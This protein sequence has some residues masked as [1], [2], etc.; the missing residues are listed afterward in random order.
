M[1]WAREAYL[2]TAALHEL[3]STTGTYYFGNTGTKSLLYDGTGFY[4]N[5]GPLVVPAA[6]WLQSSPTTGAV[7][8]GNTA[9]KYLNYDGTNFNMVGGPLKVGQGT[10][11]VSSVINAQNAG[12]A[13]ISVS[14]GA[15]EGLYLADTTHVAVGTFSNHSLA[16][17]V[18]N[19]EW[20]VID[21]NGYL[22]VKS[23]VILGPNAGRLLLAS[24]NDF[25]W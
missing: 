7:Q 1:P 18:N 15:V 22:T 21:T 23:G 24:N 3:G 9:T 25:F 13:N 10:P 5:G 19:S 2:R 11:T 14:C 16:L 4:F 12:M 20:V 8:F 6:I 17:R